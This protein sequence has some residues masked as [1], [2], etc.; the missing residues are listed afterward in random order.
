VR[1]EVL[2]DIADEER[3]HAGEFLYLLK[4]LAPDEEK[5]FKEGEEEVAEMIEKLGSS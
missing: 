3:I 1:K 5:F 2:V 4:H